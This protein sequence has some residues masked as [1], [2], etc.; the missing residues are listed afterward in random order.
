MKENRLE[1]AEKYFS[2]DDEAISTRSLCTQIPELFIVFQHAMIPSTERHWRRYWHYKECLD[3]ILPS[4]HIDYQD[5]LHVL[6]TVIKLNVEPNRQLSYNAKSLRFIVNFSGGLTSWEALR[7]T[8]E[9]H[10][11]EHVH[12]VFADTLEES[13]DLYRFLEDTER[14]FRITIDVLCDGR[15][16]W[17]VLNDNKCITI[18]GMAPC[19]Q[20]LKRWLIEDAVGHHYKIGSYVHTAGLD[21]SEMHRVKKFEA[22]HPNTICDFPLLERPFVDKCHIADFV[23]SVGI[24]IPKLYEQGFAHNNCNARCIKGGMA[25]WELKLRVDRADYLRMERKEEE[26]IIRLGR[27][28]TILKDRRGGGKGIPI[29]LG[30]FRERIESGDTSYDHNDWGAC[31]CFAPTTQSRF[32]DLLL[33][34]DVDL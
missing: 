24:K 27:K 25:H 13:K 19:S 33:Q 31:G 12:V 4:T 21:W 14:Y 15:T 10:G 3:L 16:V 1:R 6:D 28:A 26:F 7:R 32:D 23:R 5:V 22:A 17:E 2:A 8:I 30:E 29:T 20:D 18:K 11:K 9:T 34:A